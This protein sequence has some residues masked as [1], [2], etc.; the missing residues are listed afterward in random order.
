MINL[1]KILAVIEPILSNVVINCF[2]IVPS[3][4]IAYQHQITLTGI[5]FG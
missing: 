1:P 5:T 3:Q 2:V 4:G